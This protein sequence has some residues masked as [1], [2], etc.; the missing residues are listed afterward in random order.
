[1]ESP[2]M[3]VAVTQRLASHDKAHNSLASPLSPPCLIASEL[4]GSRMSKV[5][6]N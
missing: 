2:I 3:S 4:F 1:M 5:S 6:P